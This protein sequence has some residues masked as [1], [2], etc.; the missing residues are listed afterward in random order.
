MLCVPLGGVSLYEV[1]AAY[2]ALVV[3][4]ISF[5]MICGST[6]RT[7]ICQVEAPKVCALTICSCGISVT[8][9]RCN[10]RSKRRRNQAKRWTWARSTS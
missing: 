2:L 4:V 9:C 3:S 5:G 10:T 8:I 1:L 6:T 7:N